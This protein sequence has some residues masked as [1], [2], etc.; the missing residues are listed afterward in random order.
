MKLVLACATMGAA[1]AFVAPTAF[2]G[3]PLSAARTS[4]A[5][6]RMSL[7]DYKEELAETA[8][9]IAG[10][11]ES[12]ARPP[13]GLFCG[14][15]SCVRAVAARLNSLGVYLRAGL[16]DHTHMCCLFAL[17]I[18]VCFRRACV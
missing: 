4:T 11:G 2:T 1:Q 5:S 18:C 3:A 16:S 6:T 8:K 15:G 9:K 7:A 12:P 10:P 13:A 14:G 17:P